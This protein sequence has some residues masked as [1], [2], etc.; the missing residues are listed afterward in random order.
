MDLTRYSPNNHYIRYVYV[1]TTR[2]QP[3]E[4]VSARER[5]PSIYSQ[6]F[7]NKCMK[8]PARARARERQPHWAS[9]FLFPLWPRG[10][11]KLPFS[12]CIHLLCDKQEI[13]Q[14]YAQ[15]TTGE[16]QDGLFTRDCGRR[17]TGI[18]SA[19]ETVCAYELCILRTCHRAESLRHNSYPNTQ[20]I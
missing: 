11:G 8:A 4:T 17:R 14:A 3:S 6:R 1:V 19:V 13:Q 18:K 5:L 12:S 16:L 2:Y 10:I 7:I 9:V 15:R 20:L